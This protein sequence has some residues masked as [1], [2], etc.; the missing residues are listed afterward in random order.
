VPQE[1]LDP[2]LRSRGGL[3]EQALALAIE[4][5]YL[6]RGLIHDDPIQAIAVVTLAPGFDQGG[7]RRDECDWFFRLSWWH[8]AFLSL[9]GSLGRM[10]RT[11]N[12]GFVP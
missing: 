10:L 4:P 9:S 12:N 3:D 7:V 1:R 2:S 6:D 5:D 8:G 11:S